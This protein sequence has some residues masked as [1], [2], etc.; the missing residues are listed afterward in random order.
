MAGPRPLTCCLTCS[1]PH[2][3]LRVGPTCPAATVNSSGRL[4]Q[5]QLMTAARCAAR[6]P[7][8]R[9]EAA[10]AGAAVAEAAAEVLAVAEAE[11]AAAA[12]VAVAAAAVAEAVAVKPGG[13]AAGMA[14]G[15]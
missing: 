5:A 4:T 8:V 9:P 12:A 13:R 10:A 6:R 11:A 14:T 15:P 1:T 7:S 3:R 2:P